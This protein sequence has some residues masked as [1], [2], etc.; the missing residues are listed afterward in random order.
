VLLLAGLYR[1]DVLRPR[2]VLTAFPL[3]VAYGDRLS[4]RATT[5]L[6]AASAVALFL[7]PLYYTRPLGSSAP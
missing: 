4:R 2:A 1:V 5:V 3:F 6:V 7:L